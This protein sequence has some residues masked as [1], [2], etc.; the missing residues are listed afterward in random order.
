MKGPGA[1]RGWSFQNEGL[2]PRATRRKTAFG[3]G[4]PGRRKPRA[5]AGNSTGML[6][7]S[8]LK[9]LENGLSGSFLAGQRQQLELPA[10]AGQSAALLL[11]EPFGARMPLPTSRCKSCFYA[12]A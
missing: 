7:R 5:T 2:L 12:L 10:L 1:E 8:I 9:G 11:D 6:K 4:K 3:L